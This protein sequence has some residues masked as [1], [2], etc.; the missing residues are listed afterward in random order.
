M[1][2]FCNENSHSWIS[3][4]LSL[5]TQNYTVS[6]DRMRCINSFQTAHSSNIRK[7]CFAGRNCA[8]IQRLGTAQRNTTST[9]SSSGPKCL[10]PCHSKSQYL[11][12]SVISSVSYLNQDFSCSLKEPPYRD[13]HYDTDKGFSS[14]SAAGRSTPFGTIS[15][16]FDFFLSASL[17]KLLSFC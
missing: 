7:P 3:T 1:L 16:T 8:V 14:R 15:F 2:K 9:L 12:P 17:E 10:S 11:F 6:V 5:Q 13:M 4:Y